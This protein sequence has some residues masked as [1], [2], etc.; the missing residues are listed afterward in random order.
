MLPVISIPRA[1]VPTTEMTIYGEVADRHG[2]VLAVFDGPERASV[3]TVASVVWTSDSGIAPKLRLAGRRLAV[4]V[5]GEDVAE[6]GHP[7]DTRLV[8]E[9]VS[10]A[11]A[12][13]AALAEAGE[14]ADVTRRFSPD[15]V[16]LSHEV[17]SILRVT[18]PEVQEMLEAGSATDRLR[19]AV[20][21]LT[22]ETRLIRSLLARGWT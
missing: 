11:R 7:D 5:S 9:A 20:E 21:V 4:V 15:P 18:P 8:G 19:H 13:L 22:M 12:Y 17:A 14:G 3:G 2:E 10:A 1:L 16:A 6:P